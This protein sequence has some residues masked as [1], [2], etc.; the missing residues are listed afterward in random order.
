MSPAKKNASPKKRK[1]TVNEMSSKKDDKAQ[2]VVAAAEKPVETANEETS[3]PMDTEAKQSTEDESSV[4]IETTKSPGNSLE[5]T[6]S[7]VDARPAE[8]PNKSV[9]GSECKLFCTFSRVKII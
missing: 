3:S 2:T 8:S 6:T 5:T 4:G 9:E 1:V 7:T